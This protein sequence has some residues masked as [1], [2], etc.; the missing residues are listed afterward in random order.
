MHFPWGGVT[1]KKKDFAFGE[2]LFL[3]ACRLTLTI[4][5][6]LVRGETV[7][8]CRLFYTNRRIVSSFFR[9]KKKTFFFIN[10]VLLFLFFFHCPSP[11]S[12][13]PF[14]LFFCTLLFRLYER[15]A[16]KWW[17]DEMVC[18]FF[19]LFFVFSRLGVLEWILS[20]G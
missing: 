16:S 17:D 19:T 4:P 12:S 13:F 15:F 1:P 8:T 9:L 5:V 18:F 7:T 20:L 2:S 11:F 14:S 10:D 6:V 3:Y